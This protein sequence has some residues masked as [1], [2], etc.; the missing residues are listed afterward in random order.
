MTPEDQTPD[1]TQKEPEPQPQEQELLQRHKKKQ[2]LE[3]EQDQTVKFD[4][5]EPI[6][7]HIPDTKI[8]EAHVEWSSLASSPS[9]EPEHSSE[10]SGS[11][12]ESGSES[13]SKVQS[14]SD[15]V[16]M[17][18]MH[19]NGQESDILN[20]ESSSA[21]PEE[22]HTAYVKNVIRE[23]SPPRAVM[24]VKRQRAEL[25]IYADQFTEIHLG[26]ER[27]GNI[28]DLEP[29]Q[30]IRFQTDGIHKVTFLRVIGG[31]IEGKV[32]Q[33]LH[34]HTENGEGF[35]TVVVEDKKKR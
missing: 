14:S 21:D 20:P 27:K 16:M 23:F 26:T 33:I 10:S 25:N 9:S 7:Y 17:M 24:V 32:L 11:E 13:A 15:P 18:K 19:M 30:T 31:I 3:P 35:S 22:F 4:P 6:P 34:D 1:I 5:V 2:S 29:F 28:D 12:S 8:P